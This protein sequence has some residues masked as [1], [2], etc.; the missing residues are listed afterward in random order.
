MEWVDIAGLAKGAHRGEGLGNRFLGDLRD[1]QAI[2][3][4]VR[5]F[6]D[7]NVV[8]VDGKVDPIGD[9]EAIN[10][11]LLFADMAHVQRR[12]EKQNVPPDERAALQQVAEG[13]DKGIPARAVGLTEEA[14]FCIKSMGLLTL[15]PIM[16]AFNVDEVDFFLD[17]DVMMS[18]IKKIMQKIDNAGG[19]NHALWTLV[20]AKVE[21]ELSLLSR[22]EQL[23]YLSSL[24]V[25]DQDMDEQQFFSYNVLPTMAKDLLGY[26]LVY[27]GTG[28]PPERSKT[29]RAWLISNR[30]GFTAD[31]LAS[32]LHGDIHKGFIRAEVIS[33]PTLLDLNVP[34]YATVKETGSVRTEGRDYNLEG[35]DVVL[36][37]WK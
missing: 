4:V 17:R 11:E 3:H 27:T 20:S 16:Y 21:S 29:T 12:L 23:E 13:F 18:K 8:H 19:N 6:E 9:I 1:C 22:G 28:V 10:L 14:R 5:A 24:G 31:D 37:K 26:S 34:N 2:C 35:F 30:S 7:L 25:D 15:K 36:I 33:A 32:R